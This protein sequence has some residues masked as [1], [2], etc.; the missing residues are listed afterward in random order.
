VATALEK[1]RGNCSSGFV[2][3]GAKKDRWSGGSGGGM[4]CNVSD[5]EV[6]HDVAQLVSQLNTSK[7]SKLG[8]FA[9]KRCD[10]F[11]SN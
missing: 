1:R 6:E 9:T 4:S 5:L 11:A 7:F 10:E 2:G 8:E 3:F